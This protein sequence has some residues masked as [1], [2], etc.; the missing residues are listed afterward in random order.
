[1]S[2]NQQRI[3][4]ES[5]AVRLLPDIKAVLKQAAA[6]DMRSVSSL[7]LKIL[8]GWLRDNGYLDT[9]S[10]VISDKIEDTGDEEPYYEHDFHFP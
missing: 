9:A 7:V 10:P 2:D 1:M 6:D 5:L 3:R 4:R 8:T